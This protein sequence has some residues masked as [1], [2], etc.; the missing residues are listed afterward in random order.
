MDADVLIV[1]AGVA[2]LTCARTLQDAGSTTV[3]LEKSRGVGGRCATRRVEGQPVDHGLSF[4]HGTDLEFLAE[5]D[6]IEGATPL[7]GWPKRVSGTGAPCQ[8]E[9]FHAYE[10]RVAFEE[11]VNVFAKHLSYGLDIRRESRVVSLEPS[12]SRFEIET[13]SGETYSASDVVVTA[14]TEQTRELLMTIADEPPDLRAARKLLSIVGSEPSLTLLAGYSLDASPPT[15]E[16]CYPE[17][18]ET[19]L[20]ISHDSAKRR[21]KQFHVLVHQ[22]RSRWSRRNLESD[23]A[24]WTQA[25]LGEASRL[26]GPWAAKP[27]WTQ[28]HRWRYARVNQASALSSPMLVPFPGAG[29]IGLAGE[30]FAPS[31][32]VEAAWISGRRLAKR[33]LGAV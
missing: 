11:G 22:C 30:I 14:P 5:V 10:K 24:S 27:V 33:I 13:E 20:L 28:T 4:I 29:R 12:R 6:R 19:L 23:R 21:D 9:A 18:S 26:I 25:I 7:H 16:M 8:P 15:W 17:D 31:G 3:V 1:G 32:G 2:G